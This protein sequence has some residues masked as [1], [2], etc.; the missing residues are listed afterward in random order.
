MGL[1]RKITFVSGTLLKLNL[2]KTLYF[3]FKV[4]PFKQALKLPVH[5]YGK[6][7]FANLCGQFTISAAEIHFGMIVFGGK[8]EV[9][10][11]PSEK[12]RIY[13]S[14]KIDFAGNAIFGRGI[15]L[16]VWDNALL[17]IGNNFSV[18]SLCRII[19]FRNM[20]FGN[21][22]LISWE[23]QFFDT[24]FHFIADANHKIK[25]NC[26]TVSI[27]DGVWIGTR[28][29]VLKGT[30]IAAESIVAANSV[31][32]GNYKEKNGKGVLL[33]GQPAKAIK[34]SIHYITDKKQETA[35]F[36]YFSKNPNTAIDWKP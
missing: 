31:C 11:N 34:E 32:S 8:H 10:I 19:V 28:S 18:G 9:V 33:A 14:G 21:D 2:F 22:V 7:D 23:C 17:N 16:M 1:L 20:T 35:L 25:D 4:L 5:L 13:N 24:D 15:N 30:S 26:A 29:T 3:N 12:T 6:I 36:Q 27:E